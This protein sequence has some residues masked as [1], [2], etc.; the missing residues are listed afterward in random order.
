MK[1]GRRTVLAGLAGTF[2]TAGCTPSPATASF[3]LGVAS[4]DALPDS[5]LLWTRFTGKD[6]LEA[7]LWPEGSPEASRRLA[8]PLED[9]FALIEVSGLDPHTWYS[10]RFESAG[11]QLSPMGRFRTALA[12]DALET[13]TIG[14]TSCIKY[15][16]SYD[17]LA[18]AAERTDLDA[19]VFLGDAVY[20]DGSSVLADFRR[21]WAEGLSGAEYGALRGSTS[22]ITQWD[23]HEVRNDWSGDS[24]D[25]TLLAN[26]RRA[27]LDHQPIRRDA[28]RPLRFWR[29]LTWGR[30]AELFILD[31]RSERNRAEGHYISPEQ[32][33]W[34]ISG[35]TSS[36]ATFKLILNTVPI[37]EFDSAFFAPFAGDNWQGFPAQRDELLRGIE[38]SGAIFLSGDFHLASFGRVAKQGPGSTLFEALVGPGANTPNP[39]PA[40]PSGDPWEFSSAINNY[41]SLELNPFTRKATVR[42][43]SGDGRLIF[44]RVVG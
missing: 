44:E 5:A 33:E 35:V 25:P 26:A 10:F 42:Y 28:A 32:L 37:G 20:T 43:H 27:F 38:D 1:L 7:V 23:D 39:L 29:K 18:Q 17:V 2:A 9:G 30:T 8:A 13:I 4:G 3:P 12:P 36:T 21:K 24:I 6:G 31:A 40:Y 15:G 41:T 14:A 22:M 11:G 19:F 34:L 16:H